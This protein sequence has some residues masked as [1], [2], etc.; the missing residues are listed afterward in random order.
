MKWTTGEH[1]F[2]RYGFRKLIKIRPIDILQP[3]MIWH[4][5][6]T[7]TLRVSTMAAAYDIPLVSHGSSAY[8]YHFVMAQ[9]HLTFC[10]YLITS[11]NTD[12]IEPVF[13]R[14]FEHEDL[15]L[16]GRICPLEE[17]GF[18][19]KLRKDLVHFE[20]RYEAR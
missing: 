10:E 13:G 18:D 15:P 7:E 5:G 4:G 11:A 6:L 1:E 14:L 8:S 17:P 12:K 2:S 16:N 20:H 3:E 9:P 19:L